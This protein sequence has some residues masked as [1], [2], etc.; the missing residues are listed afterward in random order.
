MRIA[1]TG[2]GGGLGG[3]IPHVFLDDKLILLDRRTCNVTDTKQVHEVLASTKPDVVIHAAAYT[4][5]DGAED[6]QETARLVNEAGTANVARAT[7]ALGARLIYPSTDYVFDG[8]QRRAYRE[9]DQPRPLSVYGQ[10]KLAG[11]RRALATNP[12]T[13]VVRTSW[14]YSQR[15]KSFVATMQR[16]F[17][18]RDEI[19]IVDDEVSSPTYARDFARALEQLL[20]YEEFGLYHASCLGEASWYSF[21]REIAGQAKASVRLR[22]TTAAAWGAKAPRPA[23]STLDTSKIGGL[24]IH[25]PDWKESL[26]HY[27]QDSS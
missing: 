12:R 2:A 20:R 8:R 13:Y 1:V 22:P 3:E 17:N 26:G 19:E 7:K 24:G 6:D 25:L 16:M 15:G 10:T 4:D 9:S 27:F 18:D 5:V 14:L 23:H 11:E 21:A